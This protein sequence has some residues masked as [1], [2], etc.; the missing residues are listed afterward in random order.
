MVLGGVGGGFLSGATPGGKGAGFL[1]FPRNATMPLCW[2]IDSEFGGGGLSGGPEWLG[3][4]GVDAGWLT[5]QL[6]SNLLYPRIVMQN[7]SSERQE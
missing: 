5:G 3:F 7:R 1:D 2:L 4:T 6:N